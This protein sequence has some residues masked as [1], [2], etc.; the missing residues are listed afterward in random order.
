M[1]L[2]KAQ[3]SCTC[4]VVLPV[5]PHRT[6]VVSRPDTA[7]H[8]VATEA[9]NGAFVRRRQVLGGMAVLATAL[10]APKPCLAG[11]VEVEVQYSTLQNAIES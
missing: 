10:Y 3:A 7:C 1:K 11:Q 2:S 4:Q 6:V 8:P 5:K 9:K